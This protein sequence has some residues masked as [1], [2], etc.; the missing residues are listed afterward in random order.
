MGGSEVLLLCILLGFIGIF[1]L[2]IFLVP[3]HIRTRGSFGSEGWAIALTMKWGGLGIRVDSGT[4]WRMNILISNTPV[5][6]VPFPSDEKDTKNEEAGEEDGTKMSNL[7]A[8]RD[9]GA[10][11]PHLI[12]FLRDIFA[13]TGVEKVRLWFRG[14]FGDPVITGEVFGVVQALNGMLWPTPVH[15]EMEPLFT[16]EEPAGEGE[17]SLCIRRPVVLLVSAGRMILQ[18]ECRTAIQTMTRGE[19]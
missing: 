3:L 15:L 19:G 1:M 6:K 8:I 11:L 7:Q 14:G 12:R 9:A 13:H 5:M 4:E 10:A 16:D 18:P 17:I 2:S